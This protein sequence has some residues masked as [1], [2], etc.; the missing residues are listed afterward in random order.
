MGQIILEVFH[1][2]DTN[3]AHSSTVR[4]QLSRFS[5]LQPQSATACK[6]LQLKLQCLCSMRLPIAHW[7]TESAT[8]AGAFIDAIEKPIV[9]YLS[10]KESKIDETKQPIRAYLRKKGEEH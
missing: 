5:A 7:W 4:V 9:K 1:E 6:P 3:F 8:L 2:Q 10:G